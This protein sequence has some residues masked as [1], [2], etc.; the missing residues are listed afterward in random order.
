MKQ[1][2]SLLSKL[3]RCYNIC[4]VHTRKQTAVNTAGRFHESAG[5]NTGGNG[6]RYEY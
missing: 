5:G 4:I 6:G 2:E 1:S 3:F